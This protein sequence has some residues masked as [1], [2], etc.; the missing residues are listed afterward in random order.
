MYFYISVLL[1][2]FYGI[3][4]FSYIVFKHK[5][6]NIHNLVLEPNDIN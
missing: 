1:Y 5:K 3:C 6:T 2:Y 4:Y